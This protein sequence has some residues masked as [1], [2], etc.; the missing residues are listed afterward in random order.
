MD[1][2]KY[3]VSRVDPK[4]TINVGSFRLSPDGTIKDKKVKI[5]SLLQNLLQLLVILYVV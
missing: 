5:L 2:L 1:E 3:S 4:K